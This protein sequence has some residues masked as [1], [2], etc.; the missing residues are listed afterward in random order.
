MATRPV[1][2][3]VSA[4]RLR[5]VIVP[6]TLTDSVVERGSGR[7]TATNGLAS[8]AGIMAKSGCASDESGPRAKMSAARISATTTRIC[9]V[10]INA[11]RR[12]RASRPSTA[13]PSGA[14]LPGTVSLRCK[15]LGNFMAR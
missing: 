10:P 13:S 14:S 7:T 2:C 1:I 3:G 12:G 8:V 15:S 4:T 5:T 6:V 9:S 11:R